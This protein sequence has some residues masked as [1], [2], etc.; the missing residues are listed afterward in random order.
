MSH[1]MRLL[2]CLFRARLLSV[3]LEERLFNIL[4]HLTD[5]QGEL[6]DHI[7]RMASA[8]HDKDQG[9]PCRDADGRG[10]DRLRRRGLTGELELEETLMQFNVD[11]IRRRI[12]GWAATSSNLFLYFTGILSLDLRSGASARGAFVPTDQSTSILSSFVWLSRLFMLEYALPQRPYVVQQ[13]PSR[14]QYDDALERFQ[15]VREQHMVEGGHSVL[16]EVLQLRDFGRRLRGANGGRCL[17]Y[18]SR[19]GLAVTVREQTLPM[20]AF[21]AWIRSSIRTAQE[22]LRELLRGWSDPRLPPLS[23]L[24][25][26]VS[27]RAAGYSFL[28]ATP[29][30]RRLE[31]CAESFVLRIYKL[32]GRRKWGQRRLAAYVAAHAAFLSSLLLVVHQTGGQPARGPEILSVKVC[33]TDN[34]LRNIFVHQGLLCTIIQYNKGSGGTLVPF[35][36]ARYLPA[37]VS[38]ILYQYL[39]YVRPF[40]RHLQAQHDIPAPEQPHY[41]WPAF[42]R[43]EAQPMPDLPRPD[44]AEEGEGEEE[45][46]EEEGD[47][48]EPEEDDVEKGQREAISSDRQQGF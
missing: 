19:D 1:W 15:S 13:W 5:P 9:R 30:R 41:L 23:E 43:L 14:D 44:E 16:A 37:P 6:L 45:A 31:T 8:L 7:W 46:D 35:Y 27:C 34:T 18:W 3:Q 26:D 25:D 28:T 24:S 48:V 17:L 33:N 38:Q 12:V 11:L 29:N 21:Q 47:E 2:C 40:V 20:S 39:V 32:G 10:G 22:Q 42:C 4:H 36:V